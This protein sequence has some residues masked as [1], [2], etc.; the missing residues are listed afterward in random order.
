MLTELLHEVDTLLGV[1]DEVIDD[2]AHWSDEEHA[3]YQAWLDSVKSESPLGDLLDEVDAVLET[4]A[5]RNVKAEVVRHL[6]TM[7]PKRFDAAANHVTDALAR[8][9]IS[10]TACG[11]LE[12][13]IRTQQ[14]AA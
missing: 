6:Q 3:S 2:Y 11:V 7:S 14:A 10:E 8:G 5:E 1:D 4:P 9:V 12:E 13:S